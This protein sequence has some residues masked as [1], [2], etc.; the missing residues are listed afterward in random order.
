MDVIEQMMNG[1]LPGM[2]LVASTLHAVL[3]YLASETPRIITKDFLM[4]FNE[5][6]LYLSEQ[7]EASFGALMRTHSTSHRWK[8]TVK[9]IAH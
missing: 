6:K 5:L 7:L 4:A 3:A 2:V 9:A 1:F 8:E